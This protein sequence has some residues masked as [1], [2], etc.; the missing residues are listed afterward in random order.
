MC[1]CV[2]VCMCACVRVRV[3]V[4][5][6]ACVRVHACPFVYSDSSVL[7]HSKELHNRTTLPFGSFGKPN[8]GLCQLGN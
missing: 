8:V 5:V 6:C 1:V 7:V 4:C 2:C 3:C